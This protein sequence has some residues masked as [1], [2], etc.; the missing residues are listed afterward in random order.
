MYT[1]FHG[2]R[3]K[4]GLVTLVMACLAAAMWVRSLRIEDFVDFAINLEEQRIVSSRGEIFWWA[5][6]SGSREASETMDGILWNTEF[7]GE[8]DM[9]NASVGFVRRR[10][11]IAY[12]HATIPLTLLS[13]YLILWKPRKQ[14][15]TASNPHA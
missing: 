5:W 4:V 11:R 10:W 15:P 7:N 9:V 3:R 2:W 1:F 12:W 8:L 14:Q 13:A 6:T